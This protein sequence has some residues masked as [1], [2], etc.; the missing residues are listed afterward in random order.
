MGLNEKPTDILI[1]NSKIIAIGKALPRP[2]VDTEEFDAQGL[3][4]IPG[5]IDIYCRSSLLMNTEELRRKVHE[6]TKAGFTTWIGRETPSN[7]KETLN[8]LNRQETRTLNY[9]MHFSL[10]EF[11]HGDL[12]KIHDLALLHGIPSMSY[13]L[14]TPKAAHNDRLDLYLATAVKNNMQFIFDLNI[15]GSVDEHLLALKN[16]CNKISNYEPNTGK[17]IR[18]MFTNVRFVEE[19]QIITD[20]RHNNNAQENCDI[21]A[22][23]NYCPDTHIFDLEPIKGPQLSKILRQFVWTSVEISRPELSR[24]ECIE[25]LMQFSEEQE[26]DYN[27]IIEYFI[28]RK[29]KMI[30]FSSDKGDIH[31]GSDADFCFID[32]KKIVA[33]MQNGLLTYYKDINHNNISG[34][35]IYRRFI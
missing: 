10:D 29:C 2:S 17:K 31:V 6:D 5:L 34:K 24:K 26:F 27:E 30:G 25:Q 13:T 16:I 7:M 11:H 35:Q 23:I 22:L 12:N 21:T 18:I 20:A 3:T 4:I 15:Q 32:N 9:S 8:R 28:T 14:N 33:V 19:L 1:A